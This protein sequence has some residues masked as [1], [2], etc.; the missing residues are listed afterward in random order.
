MLKGDSAPVVFFRIRLFSAVCVCS[1]GSE[2]PIGI[3]MNGGARSRF[4]QYRT[5]HA[6]L[7][8]FAPMQCSTKCLFVMNKFLKNSNYF[9]TLQ[10]YWKKVIL[11]SLIKISKTENCLAKHVSMA[12]A[13]GMWFDSFYRI[14][15]C[16]FFVNNWKLL[17]WVNLCMFGERPGN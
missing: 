1:Y 16:C 9:H 17:F 4:V 15:D 3:I 6:N 8:V 10:S 12:R 14:D 13:D 7:C 2:K 5:A 11:I